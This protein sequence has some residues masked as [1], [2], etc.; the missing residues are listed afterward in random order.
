MF[1]CLLFA[2]G[3][4]EAMEALAGGVEFSELEIPTWLEL[5]VLV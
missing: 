2:S 3:I 4:L 5:G 1:C